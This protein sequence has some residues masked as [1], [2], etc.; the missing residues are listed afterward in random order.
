MWVNLEG[1]EDKEGIFMFDYVKDMAVS[2]YVLVV[3][4]YIGLKALNNDSESCAC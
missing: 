4:W 3:Q 1:S 2:T